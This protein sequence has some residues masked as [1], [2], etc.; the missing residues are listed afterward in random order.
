MTEKEFKQFFDKNFDSLRSYLFYRSGDKELATDLA[1]DTLIR[2]WEKKVKDEGKKT[3]GLA[4]KIA[5]DLFVSR[6]RKSNTESNYLESLEFQFSDLTPEDELEYKEL[7]EKYERTL[8]QLG[9]KQRVVFLMS[10]MEGLKYSEIAEKLG[11]SVKAVEK[12]MHGALGVF[13]EVLKVISYML[14]LSIVTDNLALWFS[15]I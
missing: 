7:K 3:V 12:R 4:Y 11:I 14:Y 10:R 6:Y 5:N 2:I 13:R 8:A 9:E 15:N 1:Q